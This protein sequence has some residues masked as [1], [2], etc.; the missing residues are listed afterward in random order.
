VGG[1]DIGFELPEEALDACSH[2]SIDCPV[3]VGTVVN[4]EMALIIDSPVTD[5]IATV[6][7]EMYNQLGQIVVCFR[8]DVNVL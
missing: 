4:Y 2:A 3:A 1:V 5:T 8:S 7:Y 6:Q